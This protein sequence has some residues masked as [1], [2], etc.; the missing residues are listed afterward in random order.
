[1]KHEDDVNRRNTIFWGFTCNCLNC[2]YHCDDHILTQ[3]L[4]FLSLHHL[5][6]SFLARVKMKSTTWPAPNVW[7]FMAQ[8]VERYSANAGAMGSN[9]VD[10]PIFFRAYFQLLKL[11]LPL[12]W[13][14]LYF[15]SSHHSSGF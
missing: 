15:R 9:P 7:V 6:V 13:S 5:H 4:Y 3:N 1:M 2:I 10:V 14:Y 8:M 11:H 12:R